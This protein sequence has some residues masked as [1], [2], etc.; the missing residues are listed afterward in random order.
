MLDYK[1]FLRRERE[2]HG[3]SRKVLAE[4]VGCSEMAIYYWETGQREISLNMADKLLVELGISFVIGYSA[5]M[6]DL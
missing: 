5:V 6:E 1:C 4:K 2:K 3:L